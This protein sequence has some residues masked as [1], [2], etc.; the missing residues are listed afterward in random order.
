MKK[1]FL[2]SL[3]TLIFS[4]NGASA[5]E[6]VIPELPVI[7]LGGIGNTIDNSVIPDASI[8]NSVI[9]STN[10]QLDPVDTT[11]LETPDTEDTSP[12]ESSSANNFLIWG[13][14]IVLGA[15]GLYLYLSK[16]DRY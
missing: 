8:N 11:P 16:R 10:T 14:I 9:D 5:T 13:G 2:L 7:D 1:I 4:I 3:I 12:S 15:G 6:L